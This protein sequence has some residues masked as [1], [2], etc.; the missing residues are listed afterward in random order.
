QVVRIAG[1]VNLDL[2][3][4]ASIDVAEG[5]QIIGDNE[6]AAIGPRL[7]TT[8]D[9]RILLL[10]DHDRVRIT[11]LRLDGQES[12]DAF[13]SVGK[14]D[15]DGIRVDK[16]NN[17]EID[18]NEIYRWRGAAVSVYDGNGGPS[19]TGD[20][21]YVGRINRDNANTVWVHDNYIHHNQH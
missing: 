16:A 2:S 14:P 20:P 1:D 3:G 13:D 8:T 11:G 12:L 5:V 4:L 10:V 17:V 6:A 19:R 7:F 15:T 18:H 9:P 21:N